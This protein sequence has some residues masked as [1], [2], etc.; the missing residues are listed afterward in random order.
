MSKYPLDFKTT[1]NTVIL[2]FL[3]FLPF[4]YI[5]ELGHLLVC[6]QLGYQGH[7]GITAMYGYIVCDGDANKSLL[8]RFSGGELAAFIAFIPLIFQKI[9]SKPYWCV[10]L[11][12]LG[13]TQ[14]LNA[15]VETFAHDWYMA[16]RTQPTI[17]F[18]IVGFAIFIGLL[19]IFARNKQ[20]KLEKEIIK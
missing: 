12:S 20:I 2:M 13:I 14:F 11:L 4:N 15:L 18:T 16:G 19:I 5:H 7:I 10:S 9:R 8:F 6:N 3:L 17:V 1:R